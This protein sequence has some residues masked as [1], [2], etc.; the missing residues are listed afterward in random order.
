MGI[1]TLR[2]VRHFAILNFS[3]DC[4][5]VNAQAICQKKTATM[6]V[7]FKCFILESDR[8]KLDSVRI[9]QGVCSA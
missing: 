4:G 7:F 8:T 9:I 2:H 3:N 5:M 1:R 6:A